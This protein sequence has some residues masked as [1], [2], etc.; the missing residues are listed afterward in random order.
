VR[1]LASFFV[2][3]DGFVADDDGRPVQLQL[4]DFAGASS[5]GLPDL[6]EHC[7]AVVMGRTTFLPAVGA[8]QW[9]WRQP[10][11]VLTSSPLPD[12]TPA[13]VTSAPSPAMLLEA[14]ERNGVSRDVHLVGGPRTVAAF[15]EIG[16]LAELRLHVVPLLLGSG[17]PLAPATAAAR[18]LSLQATQSFPDGVVELRYAF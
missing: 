1:I 14:M 9:P 2:S 18:W 5:Y 4:P 13:D 3:L 16:A 6:L 10:A 15:S 12:G 17:A 8:P 11:F 7:D